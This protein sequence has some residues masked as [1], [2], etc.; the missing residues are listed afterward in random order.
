MRR[1]W[2]VLIATA[3]A[4]CGVPTGDPPHIIPSS[5]VPY[6]LAQAA[7]T[8]AAQPSTPAATNEARVFFMNAQDGLVARSRDVGIG[9]REERLQKLLGALAAGPTEE[10]LGDQL[11]TA[12]RPDID[13][14]VQALTSGIVTVDIDGVEGAQI[15]GEGRDA[16]AQIVLTA[17]S[18]P[19][20]DGVLIAS[21]GETVEAP[22]PSGELTAAPLTA[23]DYSDLVVTPSPGN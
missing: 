22:L 12:L 21:D 14:S 16:V 2:A 7:P 10:E 4:G 13:L 3:L 9:S 19:W 11:S 23:D 8:S 20:V 15:G 17:T 1:R 5:D 6:G 18:L